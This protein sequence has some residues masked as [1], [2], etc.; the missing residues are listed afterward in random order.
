MQPKTLSKQI[1][2]KNEFQGWSMKS[3]NRS[4]ARSKM[5]SCM[6]LMLALSGA[7]L[8]HA[9]APAPQPLPA[10]QSDLHD[11]EHDVLPAL[12]GGQPPAVSQ[13]PAR[14]APA[15]PVPT[16]APAVT[17]A[18]TPALDL[19]PILRTISGAACVDASNN[20]QC[21]AGEMPVT[22]VI[23]RAGS[24]AFALSDALGQFTLSVPMSG[25]QLDITLPAGFNSL[26]GQ[27]TFTV[28]LAADQMVAPLSLALL[29]MPPAPTPAPAVL[30]PIRVELPQDIVQPVVNLSVDLQPL[31]LALAGLAGVLLLSQ[32]LITGVLRAIR[33]SYEKS[34]RH[35]ESMLADQRRQDLALHLQAPGG[36]RMVAE[37]VAADALAEPVSI[38]EEAGILDACSQPAPKFTLASRDGREFIFTV[39]PRL[40]KQQRLIDRHAKVL[41]LSKKAV[42]SAIDVAMLWEYV[43]ATRR[44]ARVTP[45][46]QAPWYLVI[47]PGRMPAGFRVAGRAP[48]Q[49]TAGQ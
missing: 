30:P 39:N 44:L 5:V 33:G 21:D 16:A 36:W 17:A 32:L 35:Q 10:D 18:A 41:K 34:F 3:A 22:N 28:P 13:P 1:R 42:T 37:Q 7:S 6:A 47:R 46:R 2:I 49:I 45:P 43:M 14:P 23:V 12:T 38:D 4:T 20:G 40:L 11:R 15:Q 9:E 24:G 19:V 48:R 27:R 26:S 25:D 8:A 29:P 31:Y